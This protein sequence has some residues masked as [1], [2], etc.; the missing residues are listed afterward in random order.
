VADT[1]GRDPVNVLGAIDLEW[2][3]S[4]VLAGSP[5][6]LTTRDQSRA[7][8]LA[9]AWGETVLVRLAAGPW[10]PSPVT[11]GASCA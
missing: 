11:K 6:P 1:E 3:I 10:H 5:Y 9:D 8:R 4:D 7:Q 2:G